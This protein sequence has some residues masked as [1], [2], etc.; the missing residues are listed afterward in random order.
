MR[1]YIF[2][3]IS[4]FLFATFFISCADKN[5]P[6]D[7]IPR[8]K[9]TMA[10]FSQAI[11]DRSRAGIDSLLVVQALDLGYSSDRILSD[12]YPGNSGTFYAFGAKTFT[13]T[14][15]AAKV[16]CTIMADSTDSGRPLEITLV[17]SGDN[18]F[19]KRF[20]LK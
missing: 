4:V 5:P 14:K 18:W 3:I 12:I 7:E 13:Y 10:K 15:D 17:K 1:N 2:S 8:I 16:D 6:R 19:V 9:E 20:D 11:K